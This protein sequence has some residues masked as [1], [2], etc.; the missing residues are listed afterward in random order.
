MSSLSNIMRMVSQLLVALALTSCM[1]QISQALPATDN[2]LMERDGPPLV[3]DL[4]T[5]PD[6]IGSKT[7]ELGEDDSLPPSEEWVSKEVKQPGGSTIVIK[8]RR[9][10]PKTARPSKEQKNPLL[11][12]GEYL[13]ATIP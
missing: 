7:I 10:K 11:S 2:M 6:E 13:G 4:L 12:S 5:S 1:V 9:R 8:R 3:D